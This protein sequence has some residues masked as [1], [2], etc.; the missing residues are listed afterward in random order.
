MLERFKVKILKLMQRKR[1]GLKLICGLGLVQSA[2]R[3]AFPAYILQAGFPETENAVSP[4]VQAL[5]LATFVLIGAAGI[6]TSYGLLSGARWGRIRTIALSMA[7]IVFDAWAMAAVQ[8]T[9]LLGLLLPIAFIAYLMAY[10]SDAIG[11][12]NTDESARG[13]RN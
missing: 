13:I 12:V 4:D 8:A 3:L 2:I 9:A 1:T 5:I 6:I 10:R 7:T 11:E